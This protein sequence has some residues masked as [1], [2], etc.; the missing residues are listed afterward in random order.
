MQSCILKAVG[1][2]ST[3]TN[4]LLDLKNSKNLD[5]TTLNKI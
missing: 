2:I 3:V 5:T 4:A 1:A